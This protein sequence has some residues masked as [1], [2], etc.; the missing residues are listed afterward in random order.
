MNDRVCVA[1]VDVV[2]TRSAG[3]YGDLTEFLGQPA[4]PSLADD[5]SPLYAVACRWA[6]RGDVWYLETWAIR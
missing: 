6:K 2:T 1:I 5:S 4:A 3:L